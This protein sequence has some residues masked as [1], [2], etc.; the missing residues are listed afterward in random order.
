M[1]KY[2]LPLLLIGV[3]V[4]CNVPKEKQSKIDQNDYSSGYI[5]TVGSTSIYKLTIDSTDYIFF[6]KNSWD[7]GIY[8]IPII[9][10]K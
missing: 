5:K 9:K 7:G 10:N 1:K 8:V 2:I 3:I 6:E 4:G